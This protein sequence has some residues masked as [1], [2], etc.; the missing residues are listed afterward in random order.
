MLSSAAML[1]LPISRGWI[2]SRTA[3]RI[4]FACALAAFSL[5]GVWVASLT[6]LRTAGVS[7]LDAF[8]AAALV[9]QVLLW[10]GIVGTALLSIAMWY[11]W[12]EFDNS[13]WLRKALWFL[14]LYLFLAIGPAFYY[15]RVYRRDAE[16]AKC[17]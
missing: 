3:R 1:Y 13:A 17:V 10:P 6:A 2:I 5:F 15:F 11:F 12:F 14:P 8:P 16:V 4:Y 7:S 9:I